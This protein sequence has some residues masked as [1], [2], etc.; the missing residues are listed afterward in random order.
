MNKLSFPQKMAYSMGGLAMNLTNLVIAQWIFKRYTNPPNVLLIGAV[1]MSV[2]F[3]SGRVTDAITDPIIGNWSDNLRSR[4]GRRIPFIMF[5]TIPFAVIFFLLWTPPS[6]TMGLLNTVYVFIMVQLYFIFYTIVVTPYLALLPEITSNLEE[7]VN[8]TTFQAV[9]V[10]IGTIFF[11]LMGVIKEHGGWLAFG[12]V[13][14]VL[15]I[16]SFYPTVFFIKEKSDIESFVQKRESS[17]KLS[18]ARSVSLT[19]KNRP[20][21]YLVMATSFYW[22][23]LNLMLMLIPYWVQNYLGLTESAV[24]VIMGPFLISNLVFFFVFNWI[25][26]KKG[27]FVAFQFMAIGSAL[28]VPALSLG[29]FFLSENLLLYSV[30]VMGVAGIP[31]A[32]FS[33]IPFAIISDIV[34]YDETISGRRREAIFFGVQ[35]IF[36]KTMIGFSIFSFGIVA[37][38]ADAISIKGLLTIPLIASGAFVLSF[39]V[40]NRYRIRERE[41]DLYYDGKRIQRR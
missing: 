13:V 17:E 19:L 41:G 26:K 12:G 38:N 35:A 21:L 16:I 2:I 28:V 39:L 23:G 11:V 7:R 36:Q 9:F 40:F 27:K 1:M 3:F 29:S 10:M 5:G 22:F 25:A 14:S 37:M 31:I 30:I 6:E 33:L 24:S 32:G 4:R 18:L 8:I 15:T 20:F 34:D